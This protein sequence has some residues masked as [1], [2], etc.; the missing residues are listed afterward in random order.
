MFWLPSL[1]NITFIYLFCHSYKSFYFCLSVR[2][3]TQNYMN[4]IYKEKWHIN[5]PLNSG[6]RFKYI[7]ILHECSIKGRK[8][9]SSGWV[10]SCTVT[11]GGSNMLKYVDLHVFACA[12]VLLPTQGLLASPCWSESSMA[13]HSGKI[14]SMALFPSSHSSSPKH[15]LTGTTPGLKYH[16]CPTLPY[17]TTQTIRDEQR[18]VLHLSYFLTLPNNIKNW[19][20]CIFSLTN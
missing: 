17:F 2:A 14:I 16:P 12:Y 11:F 3:H 18:S 5:V 20:E 9:T 1:S 7:T 10:R 8:Q 19:D 4:V 6:L 15:I 13:R